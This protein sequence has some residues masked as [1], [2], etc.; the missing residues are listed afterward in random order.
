MRSC[1]MIA[2]RLLQIFTVQGFIEYRPLYLLHFR[3]THHST[4]EYFA[5]VSFVH[6]IFN[7]FSTLQNTR[8]HFCMYQVYA[9]FYVSLIY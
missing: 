3:P 8:F 5:S 1:M 7:D 9:D 4:A 2:S 6:Y